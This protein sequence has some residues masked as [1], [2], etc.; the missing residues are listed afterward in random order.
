MDSPNLPRKFGVGWDGAQPAAA[1]RRLLVDGLKHCKRRRESIAQELSELVG[2][3]VTL[4]MLNEICRESNN[5]VRF[6]LSWARALCEITGD[7][8]LAFAAMP[9]RLREDAEIGRALRP[10]LK[11]WAERRGRKRRGKRAK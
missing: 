7:D 11:K 2:E 8:G 3:T 5:R 4:S 9:D 10:Y 1:V 6:P